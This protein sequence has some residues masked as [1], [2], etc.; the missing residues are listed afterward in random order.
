M[1]A[2]WK[3]Q[4]WA[5]L[6]GGQD[7]EVLR[8][9]FLKLV[10]ALGGLTWAERDSIAAEVA[11]GCG[12]GR[13]LVAELDRIATQLAA[14]WDDGR[15]DELRRRLLGLYA[16]VA[17]LAERAA[18]GGRADLSQIA[19][20]AVAFVGLLSGFRGRDDRAA[21]YLAMADTWAL[22]AGDEHLRALVLTW[23]ADLDSAVQ[24]GRAGPSEERVR[25]DL[26]NAEARIAGAPPAVQALVLLRQAEEHA[27]A[28][29]V[30]EAQRY[31]DHADATWSAR[32]GRQDGLYGIG[33][34]DSIHA[35]FRANVA[36]LSRR[37]DVAVPILMDVLKTAKGSNRAA[38]AADLAAAL[39]QRGDVDAAAEL[40]TTAWTEAQAAGLATRA[41]RIRGIRGRELA[42]YGDV[43]AVR[44]L[45]EALGVR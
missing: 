3:G 44:R 15:T 38:A 7:D 4:D 11:R 5:R 30:D 41:R 23:M 28:G 35:A 24:Q 22:E 21:M 37:P 1:G 2:W 17:Q 40:L 31:L 6:G 25:V 8:R 34:P 42:A 16:V 13:E 36:V 19:G 10:L 12:T 9:D 29:D 27:A 20:R 39:A 33:W 45:D 43:P 32:A 26:D 18:P 14:Q